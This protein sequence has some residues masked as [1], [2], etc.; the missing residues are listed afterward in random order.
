MSYIL[1]DRGP[2]DPLYQQ[3]VE[4]IRQIR[5]PSISYVQR[6]LKI[7][8]NRAAD[9]VEAMVG[10]VLTSH[11]PDKGRLIDADGESEYASWS[12]AP[13]VAASENT[14]PMPE[15]GKTVDAAQPQGNDGAKR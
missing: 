1:P 5:R 12:V 4:L 2:N 7:G 6:H 14:S 15:A 10:T 3:A 11:D 8:Y 9:M 13:G